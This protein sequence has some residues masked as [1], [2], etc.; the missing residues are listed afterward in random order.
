[1]RCL[2]LSFDLTE[3]ASVSLDEESMSR[4]PEVSTGSEYAN[5]KIEFVEYVD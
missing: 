1:M 5:T 4:E 2:E 3:M